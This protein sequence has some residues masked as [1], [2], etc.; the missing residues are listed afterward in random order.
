MSQSLRLPP[1]PRGHQG[2]QGRVSPELSSVPELNISRKW[3]TN[4]GIRDLKSPGCSDYIAETAAN[5]WPVS[6][7]Q[8]SAAKR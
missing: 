2:G 4:V 1:S 7:L 8:K 6:Q 3:K 5:I